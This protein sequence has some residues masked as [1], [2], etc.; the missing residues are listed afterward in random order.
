MWTVATLALLAAAD[1]D[2]DRDGLSDF[3][4]TH[5]Y[6]TDPN[7][8]DSDGDGIP[9]GDWS[10]RR[11]FT[12]SVRAIMQVL[13]PVNL[14]ELND[15]YQDARVLEVREDGVEI[16]VVC[17]PLNT[18]AATLTED[19][20]WRSNV[21][22]NAELKK[23]LEPGVT[24]NWDAALRTQ[25]LKDL[26]AAGIDAATLSDRALVEKASRWLMK[27]A[28][29][30]KGFTTF[31]VEFVNGVPRVPEVLEARV[32]REIEKAGRSLPEQWDRE[33]FGK[34]MYENRARG[35]CT[36]SAIYQSTCLRALGL[37]TRSVL[38]IPIIDGD[39]DQQVERVK[40]RISHPAVKQAIL[41][42]T[43]DGKGTW[44]SHTFNEVWIG[45][46]WRRLNYERL[47]QNI[48]DEKFL[49]LMIH[50]NTWRDHSEAG[51]LPWGVRHASSNGWKD[52]LFGGPNPYRNVS[53]SDLVGSHAKAEIAEQ[54]RPPA[55]LAVLTVSKVYWY[56]DPKKPASVTTRNPLDPKAGHLLV[57]VDERAASAE[58]Y[59]RFV[60]KAPASLLLRAKGQPD[61]P[62]RIEQRIWSDSKKDLREIAL[63]IAPAAFASMAPG[64]A[65][66]L[67]A[68]AAA[69]GAPQWKIAEGITVIRP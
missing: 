15:D 9:D 24:A 12:Y 2:A 58:L 23:W 68:P 44:H 19:P 28:V 20:Q 32:T 60:S 17:Y 36:S 4:E 55:D 47:G 69:A 62:A 13:P 48:L 66:S 8:S 1:V 56:D 5:K 27:R 57:H 22:K 35:T 61:V 11:E 18:N 49:G 67:V 34:A 7:K 42:A 10:E 14:A 54:A 41:R 26:A 65:Y 30:E 40:R 59:S 51:L 37:P 25:L 45:A 39:D 31:D 16:E 33:L 21:A 6:F 38:F 53:L 3:A 43:A 64:T 52:D 29:S 63:T 50:V 46:R